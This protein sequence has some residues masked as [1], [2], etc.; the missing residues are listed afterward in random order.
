MREDSLINNIKYLKQVPDFTGCQNGNMHPTDI[1][2][3]LEFDDKYLILFEAKHTCNTGGLPTG[4]KLVLERIVNAW[5][6]CRTD[7][8]AYLLDHSSTDDDTYEFLDD[9]IVTHYYNGEWHCLDVLKRLSLRDELK[10]LSLI[11]DAPKLK[12]MTI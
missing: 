8:I 1:D 12:G 2:A 6:E 3:L 4:Q 5:K 7:A 10:R 11:W 9:T